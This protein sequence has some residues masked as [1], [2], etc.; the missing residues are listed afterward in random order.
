MSIE[1][2]ID[3]TV[4]VNINSLDNIFYIVDYATIT[5]DIPL[6]NTQLV[7]K[8]SGTNGQT[9]VIEYTGA[10][11]SIDNHVITTD[12]IGK[13]IL[14]KNTSFGYG[15]PV[16]VPEIFIPSGAT[17][18]AATPFPP[19]VPGL[20]DFPTRG[21][22]DAP[23]APPAIADYT[24]DNTTG[25][26]SPY[27][28]YIGHPYRDDT[29]VDI[30]Q[31]VLGIYEIVDVESGSP[32][33]TPNTIT[34]TRTK[35]SLN[36]LPGS[37]IYV[38]LGVTNLGKQFIITTDDVNF[39][40]GYTGYNT[41][42]SYNNTTNF[43]FTEQLSGTVSGT[44]GLT[45][46]AGIGT[47]FT[48]EL[49]VTDIILIDGNFQ[50]EE[51]SVITNNILLT[52]TPAFASTFAN[53]I[54]SKYTTGTQS[55]S[56]FQNTAVVLGENTDFLD[57]VEA[58]FT[59]T[60]DPSGA[61]FTSVVASVETNTQ[62]TLVDTYTGVDLTNVVMNVLSSGELIIKSVSAVNADPL[63]VD[64]INF[65][66]LNCMGTNPTINFDCP[67]TTVNF[68]GATIIGLSNFLVNP[69]YQDH[70]VGRRLETYQLTNWI[71]DGFSAGVGA[72]LPGTVGTNGVDTVI[73]GVGTTFL[74]TFSPGDTF[75]VNLQVYTVALVTNDTLLDIT[76]PTGV[77][78]AGENYYAPGSQ[79]SPFDPPD[80]TVNVDDHLQIF[81][82]TGSVSF[83]GEDSNGIG[84]PPYDDYGSPNSQNDLI[85]IK[86]IVMNNAGSTLATEFIMDNDNYNAADGVLRFGNGLNLLTLDFQNTT[87]IANADDVEL[88]SLRAATGTI[89]ILGASTMNFNGNDIT[90]VTNA[91]ITNLDVENINHP[92]GGTININDLTNFT[93]NIGLS[94]AGIR[95]DF[96]GGATGTIGTASGIEL[97]LSPINADLV[98]NPTGAGVIDANGHDIV[99][100][101]TISMT[102]LEVNNISSIAGNPLTLS[103]V[104]GDAIVLN[105]VAGVLDVNIGAGGIDV[106]TNGA[107]NISS[108]GAGNA[109]IL[110]AVNGSL[111]ISAS[112]NLIIQSDTEVVAIVAL[113]SNFDCTIETPFLVSTLSLQTDATDADVSLTV[114]GLRSGLYRKT[115]ILTAGRDLD[116][117]LVSA[118]TTAI[119]SVPP[120]FEIDVNTNFIFRISNPSAGGFAVTL[121][122]AAVDPNWTEIGT[123][124]V[125]S[126]TTRT[127][128][129]QF[130]TQTTASIINLGSMTI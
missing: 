59:V 111:G 60:I 106:D 92:L 14:I 81:S 107:V 21:V 80:G 86:D 32:P 18:T 130:L 127:F 84:Y 20:P 2:Y 25:G 41:G 42:Y 49:I 48:T 82:K 34:L 74:T 4:P 27:N 38:C 51:V 43:T 69:L 7:R 112:D 36:I 114:D 85:N 13:K 125:A 31:T 33:T 87:S 105:T 65:T 54:Y 5:G 11:P 61:N 3:T 58:G 6:G 121:N 47:A 116:F 12:D 90:N 76:A 129:I 103:T 22:G 109:I 39:S 30:D 35:E 102:N 72:Q 88:N 10:P 19:N 98:L 28:Y 94:G 101:G 17:P 75:I 67:G 117:P 97:I 89:N 71:N 15:S 93:R 124:T 73:N 55:V 122:A 50:E 96:N 126:G 100:I 45:T 115:G 110:D 40:L 99:N 16:N 1:P 26:V 9:I 83:M 37:E 23:A 70:L 95:I 123:M 64:T 68:T 57:K 119:G 52:V 24:P 113:K 66:N 63:T 77:A 128:R 62:L 91:D 44:G 108:T 46:L 56:I 79:T 118:L 78:F 104:G 8:P 29:V 120:S 53:S